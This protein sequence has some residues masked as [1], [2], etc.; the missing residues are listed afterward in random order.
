MLQQNMT[1]KPVTMFT[2]EGIIDKLFMYNIDPG[3]DVLFDNRGT[4]GDLKEILI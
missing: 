2:N 4:V 1:G 3:D